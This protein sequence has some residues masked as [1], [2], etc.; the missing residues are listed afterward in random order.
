MDW[1]GTERA[2]GLLASWKP[3]GCLGGAE[4]MDATRLPKLAEQ[5]AEVVSGRCGECPRQSLER[6]PYV[7]EAVLVVLACWG[8]SPFKA[9]QAKPLPRPGI[10]ARAMN[11]AP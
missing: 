4:H 5:D 8:G 6:G 1:I 9:E 2:S 10:N 3:A 7:R 11:S